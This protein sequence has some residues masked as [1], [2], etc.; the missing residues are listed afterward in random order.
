QPNANT[1][2]VVDAVKATLPQF[3]A[4]F[5]AS[6]EMRQV[7]DRSVSIREAIADVKHTLFITIVLVVLV[8]FL[9]LKRLSATAIPLV[10]LPI[11]LIGC[12]ALMLWLDY[13]LD[14]ISLLAI[15]IAVGLVVD[16]AIVMLENIVRHVEEGMPPL[17][18]ALKGSREVGFTIM[19]ISISLVAVFIPIFFMPGVIGLM[20]HE[21]AA[22]VSLAVMVSALVSL[23]LVPMLCS[24]YLKREDHAGESRLGRAFERF[25][26]RVL[27]RYERGLDWC[28]AHRPAVLLS[29]FATF[30]LTVLLFVVIPKGFFPS[31]DIGQIRATV[32]GPQDASYPTMV[33]LMA[34]ASDLVRSDPNVNSVTS[35]TGSGNSGNMFIELKPRKERMPMDK[36]LEQL[37]R[38][39]NGIPGM[40]VYLSPVQNLQL[41]GRQS[42]IST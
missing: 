29:A 37:R 14:N 35:R 22:V 32:E 31:E 23:T 13:S 12:F 20:F 6:I 15:T 40:A 16:D 7:N 26:N 25:F 21:F 18:A 11:S 39:V 1:V 3:R 2:A 33:K 28:L 27:H 4:Q 5:P 30:V 8:I 41:G 10:S 38:K 42:A 34:Q 9:F 36:V 19:S 24:R 17:Q